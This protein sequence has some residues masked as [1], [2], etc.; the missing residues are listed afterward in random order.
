M[1][2][3]INNICKKIF[4]L[5]VWL[6]VL[7]AVP[8]FLALM[9]FF[10]KG[11]D[12]EFIT[13]FEIPLYCLSAYALII[14]C[15]LVWRVLMQVKH[16]LNTIPL[17][18]KWKEDVHFRTTVS[19]VPSL[20]LNFIYVITNISVSVKNHAVWFAYLGVYY[21]LLTLMKS[22]L[23]HGLVFGKDAVDEKREYRKYR[24][25]GISL[26]LMNMILSSVSAY[27]VEKNQSYHYEGM[28]I[29]VMAAMA[30]YSI[31]TAVINLIKYRRLNRPILS[32]VKVINLTVAMVTMLA[33]ETAMISQ[34]GQ[35]DGEI[36]RR[37]M[38]S[39]TTGAVCF[40]EFILSIYM[41]WNGRR[42]LKRLK[43]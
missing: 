37:V 2:E 32:A 17:W 23:L 9:W 10:L 13:S 16:K 28:L 6:T 30:F 24:N 5:P 35:T 14:V 11:R 25:C 26:L 7:I 29:Y 39:L 40:I 18:I 1:K 15:T 31:I 12:M 27:I 8:S 41:I 42:N 34:F 38:T 20:M 19:I 36:F 21:L 33:L 43:N 3:K 22:Y 4:V